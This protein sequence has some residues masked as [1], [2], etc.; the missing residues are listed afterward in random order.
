MPSTSPYGHYVWSVWEGLSGPDL[1]QTVSVWFRICPNTLRTILFRTYKIS[2]WTF[3]RFLILFWIFLLVL[4]STAKKTYPVFVFQRKKWDTRPNV[5]KLMFNLCLTLLW[6][7]VDICITSVGDLAKKCYLFK[8][9]II[10]NFTPRDRS[11]YLFLKNLRLPTYLLWICLQNIE[12]VFKRNFLQE[13][14]T[15]EHILISCRKM[16]FRPPSFSTSNV[17]HILK[18]DEETLK[19]VF[20]FLKRDNFLKNL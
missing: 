11:L 14:M 13:P 9:C 16:R 19:E 7:P 8:F 1:D 18:D 20:Q 10:Y 17:S 5:L 2:V 4:L 12:E 15:I 6:T 3:Y